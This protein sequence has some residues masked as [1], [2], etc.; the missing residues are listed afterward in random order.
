MSHDYLNVTCWDPPEYRGLSATEHFLKKDRLDLLICNKTSADKCPR[1]CHCFYQPKNRRTVINCTSV[2]LTALPKFVP[3][4][5]NLTL[6]FDGNNIEFLEHREYF[7]R[8]SV[9]SISNNKLNS[10]ASNA[11]GSIGSNT[12]LD[13]SGNSI[14]ELP[15]D[16]QSFDPCIMKLGI[17]KISCSCDDH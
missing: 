2:G 8:S 4:G 7:N 5:D 10:I 17:I 12:V 16:I 15:R 11:I 1:K 9:I 13:L 3:E 6:L 14:N